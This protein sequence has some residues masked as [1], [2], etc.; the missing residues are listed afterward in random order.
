[1]PTTSKALPHFQSPVF[2]T[3]VGQMNTVSDIAVLVN[4]ATCL[5][6]LCA[7]LE[8][9]PNARCCLCS[10]SNT[11]SLQFLFHLES[12]ISQKCGL[13]FLFFLLM[14]QRNSQR[15]VSSRLLC[16]PQG[17][18]MRE[19]ASGIPLSVRGFSLPRLISSSPKSR[20]SLASL[21]TPVAPS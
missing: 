19:E 13:F 14:A 8:I 5:Q 10:V 11:S 16:L 6:A 17:L 7:A 18:S 3:A 2:I 4:G 9:N 20:G 1:M 12:A 15:D 21:G